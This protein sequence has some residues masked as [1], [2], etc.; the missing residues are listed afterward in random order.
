[1]GI[2]LLALSLCGNSPL[3]KL[4][5]KICASGDYISA[6]TALRSLVLTPSRSVLDLPVRILIVSPTWQGPVPA[7]SRLGMSGEVVQ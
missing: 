4:R 2:T 6:L 1:M 3:V 7:N 5:L